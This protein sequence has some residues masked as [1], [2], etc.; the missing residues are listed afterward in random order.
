MMRN[1]KISIEEFTSYQFFSL[2]LPYYNGC[3]LNYLEQIADFE[4]SKLLQN[5]DI[6]CD[7]EGSSLV[8]AQLERNFYKHFTDSTL[9]KSNIY[10]FIRIIEDITNIAELIIPAN[11]KNTDEIYSFINHTTQ[12]T[13][14]YYV[15]DYWGL[16]P[17]LL[18]P[19]VIIFSSIEL[20]YGIE[21]INLAWIFCADNKLLEKIKLR[22]RLIGPSCA[23]LSE[24]YALIILRNHR[25]IYSQNQKILNDNKAYAEEI[26][27]KNKWLDMEISDIY[28]WATITIHKRD[29][30]IKYAS[31]YPGIL[32]LPLDSSEDKLIVHIG[33]RR[34][35]S[36]FSI[37]VESIYNF[38]L[39]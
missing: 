9:L 13:N 34:F 2:A 28:P 31:K 3:S 29:Q 32:V 35:L 8:R 30:F 33:K 14:L 17:S 38:F 37:L 25:L 6:F 16:D 24:V 4:C 19:N 27:K 21:G 23:S 15:I 26:H 1:R 36:E 12:N 22:L 11:A 7:P 18:S 10:D 39:Q 5:K 20:L